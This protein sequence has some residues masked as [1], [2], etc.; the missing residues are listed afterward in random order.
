M[1]PR[2]GVG[3]AFRR[4]FTIFTERPASP[5][6]GSRDPSHH[7]IRRRSRRA[8]LSGTGRPLVPG[9]AGDSAGAR[10]AVV[11]TVR[12]TTGPAGAGEVGN[13]SGGPRHRRITAGGGSPARS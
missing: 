2:P 6:R 13:F 1:G 3:A 11:G 12:G 5:G 7:G 10:A 4:P 8:G 9:A